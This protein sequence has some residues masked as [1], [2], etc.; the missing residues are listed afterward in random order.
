MLRRI[1]NTPI[2]SKFLDFAR[3][4]GL[5]Y[6]ILHFVFFVAV[7]FLVLSARQNAFANFGYILVLFPVLGVF[8]GYCMWKGQYNWWRNILIAIS[9]LI[10][11]LALFISLVAAPAMEEIH[12]EDA[13]LKSKLVQI[14]KDVE[15]MFLGVY[16]SN[17]DIVQEQLDKNVFVDARNETGSTALHVAQN[18]EIVK[19]LID[20]GA[21]VNAVDEN[22]M[23][24]IFNK[25]VHLTKLLVEAGADIHAKSKKGNTPLMW[26]CYSGYL[27]GVKY[28][29][30]LGAEVN[31]VNSDGQTAYDIAEHFHP[32]ELLDYLNA[33]GAN[34]GKDI[35]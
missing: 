18:E 17:V 10:F 33:V 29:V 31:S 8:A 30:S 19:L 25:E 5:L 14:D 34:S 23:T 12:K 26:Y 7:G 15:K 35:K 32:L 22:N 9:L 16:S 24:P 21:D 11:G 6:S 28:M 27:E 1:K 3:I 4:F 13:L 2:K 20:R